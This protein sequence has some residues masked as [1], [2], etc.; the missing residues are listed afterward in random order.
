MKWTTK[1][2][3]EGKPLADAD[4]FVDIRQKSRKSNNRVATASA[5]LRRLL[6]RSDG[7]LGARYRRL[8]ARLGGQ[9]AVKAMA[10]YLAWAADNLLLLK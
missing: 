7:Y 2:G 1:L 6:W 4:G 5:W 8:R 9:K 10:R 3:Q